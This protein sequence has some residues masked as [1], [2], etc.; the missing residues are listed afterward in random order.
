VFLKPGRISDPLHQPQAADLV[1]EVVS[2]DEEDRQ[3]D[4]VTKRREYARAGIAEYWIVDPRTET[5]TV[6]TLDGE[7][8]RLHGEFRPGSTAT[9]VLIPAFA[10]PVTA[11]FEAG[12]GKVAH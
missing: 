8:Y 7:V 2:D 5:I 12:R 4:L 3:R 1:M 6:L 9:S 10:A 11:V